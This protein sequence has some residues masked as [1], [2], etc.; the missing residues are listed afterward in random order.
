MP[1][2]V[3]HQQKD[4]V[5]CIMHCI[6]IFFC[7]CIGFCCALGAEEGSTSTS[8]S[9]QSRFV[10]MVTNQGDI[11]VELLPHVAPK[12]CQNF[13]GHIQNNYYDGV[14]F[15]RIIPNFMIQGGDPKGNGTGGE[16]IWGLPFDDEFDVNVTFDE[17]GVIA[18]ANSGPNTNGSQFFI[19]TV[20]TE[21]L[22]MKHTIFGNVIKGFD[23][24]Q[25][26]EGKGTRSGQPVAEQ[27]ILTMNVGQ[28]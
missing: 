2:S 14:I 3:K 16:S 11:V 6:G 17:P 7:L 10:T 12:A 5:M 18:M 13:L 24:V 21:W 9:S 28:E 26:I 25:K 4:Y 20:P 8:K 22:H 23:V 15:H 19:T 27:K 1:S